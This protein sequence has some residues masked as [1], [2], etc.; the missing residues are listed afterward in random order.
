MN[1]LRVLWLFLFSPLDH[2]YFKWIAKK[3]H[4]SHAV[5]NLSITDHPSLITIFLAGPTLV[6]NPTL[7]TK[8]ASSL[9]VKKK[10]TNRGIKRTW[11][12]WRSLISWRGI[13]IYAL[14]LWTRSFSKTYIQTSTHFF[15]NTTQE[16]KKKKKKKRRDPGRTKCLFLLVFPTVVFLQ[17]PAKSKIPMD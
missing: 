9:S 10:K 7:L 4:S 8:T 3:S 6:I 11:A 1:A 5:W 12:Y 14:M 2:S 17:K 15:Q 16:M 13:Y